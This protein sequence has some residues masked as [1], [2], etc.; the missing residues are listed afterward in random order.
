MIHEAWIDITTPKA[1]LIG[2]WQRAQLRALLALANDIVV[3]TEALADLFGPKALHL[4]P[5]ATIEPIRT[6][7][8]EAKY[9]LGLDGDFVL[10]LFGRGHPSRALR[11]AEAAIDAVAQRA[12]S[13]AITVLNLG[14]GAP[15][16]RV[17]QF[18][19]QWAPGAL[20]AE[21]LSL[22]LHASDLVLLPFEDGLST[23]RTTLMASLAHGL[24]VLGLAGPR[25]D[26]LLLRAVDSLVLTTLGDISGFAAAA[27]ALCASPE[28][29][30]SIGASGRAFYT[31]V[32]DWPVL[33]S[34]LLALLTERS[35]TPPKNTVVRTR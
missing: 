23:R 30:T 10:T 6:T 8:E 7:P 16:V 34:R 28:R 20:T 2:G 21:D 31:R 32:F 15:V 1:A 11:Y 3:S 24:P 29:R 17:P 27:T 33:A 12:G 25:T 19:K 4:P 13:N 5:A 18:V 9:A 22:H 14:A 26:R 35:R